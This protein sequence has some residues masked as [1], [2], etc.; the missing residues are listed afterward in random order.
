VQK[1]AKVLGVAP[2]P[3]ASSSDDPLPPKLSDY[4]VERWA[5]HA[6]VVQNEHTRQKSEAPIKYLLFYSAIGV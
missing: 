4:F 2:P 1:A 5:S 3:G 6:L